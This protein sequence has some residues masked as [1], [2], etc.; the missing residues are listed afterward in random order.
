MLFRH[1]FL[2]GLQN[3][4]VTL[5]FRRWKRPT[6]KAG[7]TLQTG[8][9]LLHIGAVEIV[10]LENISNAD[11]RRAGHA[12]RDA[13]VAELVERP[14]GRIYRVELG[15]LEPD[16]RIA[17]R[18]RR[19]DDSE[20]LGLIERLKRLDARAAAPWTQRVLELLRDHPAIRAGDLC[21]KFGQDKDTFKV[22]VRKLKNLGLTE[23]LEVGYRLS[24][25][26]VALLETL[27]P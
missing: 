6:V 24:P 5:A 15:P 14:E 13:L 1:E 22:N 7:G 11:A 26:G 25:R 21:L 18:G 17:L 9:G 23:S 27:V 20:L 4:S 16:P 8:V 3:G 19:P 2:E 10:T 12:S